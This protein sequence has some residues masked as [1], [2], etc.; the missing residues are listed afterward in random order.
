MEFPI[1]P[2]TPINPSPKKYFIVQKLLNELATIA[3]FTLEESGIFLLEDIRQPGEQISG[4]RS[5]SKMA[6]IIR[7]TDLFA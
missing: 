6:Q 5:L 2:T 7:R 4:A 3:T 1:G